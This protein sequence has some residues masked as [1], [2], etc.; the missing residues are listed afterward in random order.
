MES[1]ELKTT[2]LLAGLLSN[3]VVSQMPP[4]EL[5][6]AAT[7]FCQLINERLR[8]SPGVESSSN[9]VALLERL[10]RQP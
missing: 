9:A 3:P 5:L 7:A 1:N 10:F 4:E 2:I 6:E 8:P